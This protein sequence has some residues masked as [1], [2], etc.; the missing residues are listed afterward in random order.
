MKRAV[1]L[2]ASVCAISSID[3]IAATRVGRPMII[4]RLSEMNLEIW[5]EHDPEWETHLKQG[6]HS[7]TFAAETPA[8]TYPPT[9]MSWTIA[10]TLKFE[11]RE[12]ESAARGVLH[13][14]ATRYR[15]HPPEQISHAQYGDLA[16]YEATLQAEV[17]NIPVEVRVFCGHREGKPMVVMQVVTLKGKLTHVAEHVRRSWTHLRYLD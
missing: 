8:L 11:P 9:H 14:I 16:G 17:Q 13:Q 6:P 7:L 12:L 15:A 1:L 2:I 4:H 3:V 5:T 10:P